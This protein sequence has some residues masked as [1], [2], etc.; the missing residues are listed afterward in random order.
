MLVG[1]MF[2]LAYN[3]VSSE[4]GSIGV[5]LGLMD[6]EYGIPNNEN[7]D[8]KVTPEQLRLDIQGSMLDLTSVSII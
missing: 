2:H 7:L 6:Y 3:F 4:K 1:G 8:A 5:A